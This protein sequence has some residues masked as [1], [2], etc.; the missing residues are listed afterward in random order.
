MPFSISKLVWVRIIYWLFLT[1]MVAAFIWWYVALVQQNELLTATKIETLKARGEID[2][3][4]I[5]S[6]EAFA[7]RK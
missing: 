7:A 3:Q 4:H 6:I 2:Q 5:A 1:Y